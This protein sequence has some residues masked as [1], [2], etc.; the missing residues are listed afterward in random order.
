MGIL[1]D[2]SV[3]RC[4]SR[5]GKSCKH[6]A[7]RCHLRSF[8][9]CLPRGQEQRQGRRGVAEGDREFYDGKRCGKITADES[10]AGTKPKAVKEKVAEVA[11][12]VLASTL[13]GSNIAAQ[14]RAEPRVPPW[15]GMWLPPSGRKKDRSANY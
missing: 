9:R 8:G 15:A 7:G 3:R 6:Y 11:R 14:G 12:A 13:K 5:A 10:Q 4:R 2:W 1:S